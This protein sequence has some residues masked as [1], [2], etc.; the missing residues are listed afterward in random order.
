MRLTILYTA[1]LRGAIQLL[2]RL[3]TFLRQL[4]PSAVEDVLLLDAGEACA[5]E[6]WHCAVTGGRSMLL[7]LD[8][9]GYHAANA[10][11]Y[12]TA[13]G[14]AKLA[15]NILNLAVLTA[16]DAWIQ[17]GVA[18]TADDP[19]DQNHALHVALRSAAE[20][21]LEQRTL[22]LATVSGGQIGVVEIGPGEGNG[23]LTILNTAIHTL[24]DTILPDPTIAATV[25]FVLSEARYYQ[26]RRGS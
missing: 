7:A 10:T 19:P 8:A 1:N 9:M 25:E 4:K 14:R 13:E 24:P 12:L 21:R 23:R 20:T 3:Y 15:E 2:P 26:R 11:G 16:G 5:A 18:V 22:H 6:A 17:D